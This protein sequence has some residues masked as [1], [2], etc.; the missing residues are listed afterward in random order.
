MR[1]ALHATLFA[2]RVLTL[3]AVLAPV[4]ASAGLSDGAAAPPVSLMVQVAA[5]PASQ[6]QRPMSPLRT[7]ARNILAR[8]NPAA[9]TVLWTPD[10]GP[11]MWP[12]RLRRWFAAEPRRWALFAD[13]TTCTLSLDPV[14]R[15]HWWQP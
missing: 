3:V 1:P 4:A 8:E 12:W 10:I 6:P 15:R 7:S 13:T 2:S 5:A 14:L 9:D 11:P